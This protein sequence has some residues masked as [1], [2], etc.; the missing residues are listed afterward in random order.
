[1]RYP[2]RFIVTQILEYF[3]TCGPHRIKFLSCLHYLATCALPRE[4]WNW[5]EYILFIVELASRNAKYAASVIISWYLWR[6]QRGAFLIS[7]SLHARDHERWFSSPIVISRPLEWR[8]W[9]CVSCSS[10]RATI[11]HHPR[12]YNIFFF[13]FL[14]RKSTSRFSHSGVEP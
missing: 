11:R 14:R 12:D 3:E 10:L 9:C 7:L 4:H 1:M 13:F 2:R 6:L 5:D 8:W